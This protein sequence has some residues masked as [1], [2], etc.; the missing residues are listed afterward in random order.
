MLQIGKMPG[1]SFP[2]VTIEPGSEF[3]QSDF[4]FD[5]DKTKD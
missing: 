2:K 4:L 5:I 3:G 1:T